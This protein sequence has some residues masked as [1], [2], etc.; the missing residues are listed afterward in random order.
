EHARHLRQMQQRERDELIERQTQLQTRECEDQNALQQVEQ[1]IDTTATELV[2]RE[3]D[4]VAARKRMEDADAAIEAAERQW[5]LFTVKDT[6]QTRLQAE[7]TQ[8]Q[9]VLQRLQQTRT[10]YNKREDEAQ[11]LAAA[12]NEQAL[13]TLAAGVQARVEQVA[14]EEARMQMQA[15]TL[16]ELDDSR[17][18]KAAA[19]AAMRSE[20]AELQARLAA[21]KAMQQGVLREDDDTLRDWLAAQGYA[22]AHS[23]ARLV[24]AP[25]E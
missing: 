5:S 21:E 6:P 25:R 16:V 4:C 19:S 18:H 17:Q 7:R 24:D 23:V 10:T 3:Q 2:E 1:G 22:D 11:E 12:D 15:A 9:Y 14:A 20:L 13:Q 8:R